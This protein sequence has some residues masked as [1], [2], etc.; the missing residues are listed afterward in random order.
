MAIPR[1]RKPQNIGANRNVAMRNNTRAVRPMPFGQQPQGGL[2]QNPAVGPTPQ[3]QP[4][5][6]QIQQGG[7]QCPAGQAARPGPDG[8]PTCMPIGKA[9]RT[10][11]GI[12]APTGNMP[13]K[14]GY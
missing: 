8:R 4:R 2:I 5:Q 13:N 9:P 7:L 1:K 6:P 10:G 12:P 14:A 3:A 11:S